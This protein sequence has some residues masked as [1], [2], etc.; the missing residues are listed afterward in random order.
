MEID[1]SVSAQSDPVQISSRAPP[2]NSLARPRLRPGMAD[3]LDKNDT[4][5]HT[6]SLRL[7]VKVSRWFRRIEMGLLGNC[8]CLENIR[9]LCANKVSA[10]AMSRQK[11]SKMVSLVF[12]QADKMPKATI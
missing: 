5:C 12:N 8:S 1:D 2:Q 6:V 7:V 9:F 10:S 11:C 4:I 3:V